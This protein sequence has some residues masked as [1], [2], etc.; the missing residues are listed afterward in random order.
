MWGGIATGYRVD[1]I[2]GKT[3]STTAGLAPARFR[4]AGK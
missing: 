2:I 3:K 1:R 4:G